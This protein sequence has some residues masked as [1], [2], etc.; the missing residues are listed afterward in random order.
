MPQRT[1]PA[2]S[3]PQ[4][5]FAGVLLPSLGAATLC[6]SGPGFFVEL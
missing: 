3:S 6:V 2:L 1:L 4:K 5:S